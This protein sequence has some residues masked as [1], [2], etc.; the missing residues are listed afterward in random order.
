MKNKINKIVDIV[1][2]VLSKIFFAGVIL[3]VILLLLSRFTFTD[4][5]YVLIVQSGSMEPAIRTGAVVVVVKS[6]SYMP[7]DIITFGEMSKAKTPTT[8]RIMEVQN[9]NGNI[10]YI[11]KGDAND[12]ADFEPIEAD[13]IKGKVFFSVPYFGYIIDLARK[14]WGF[15]AIIGIPAFIIVSDEIRKIIVELK[16]RKEKKLG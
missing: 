3:V 16:K 4:K 1:F 11:T 12:T 13:K 5:F 2:K 10:S 8:H 15:A 9:D 6:N 7:G 14:P